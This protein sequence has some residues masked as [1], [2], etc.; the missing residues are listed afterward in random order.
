MDF[1]LEINRNNT[2]KE[3]E[4]EINRNNNQKEINIEIE[5]T[6]Q[7]IEKTK[8]EI[9]KTKQIDKNLEYVNNCYNLF[10]DDRRLLIFCMNKH[11]N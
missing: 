9:E 3:I 2:Q 11:F 4:I 8:Q 1:F 10:N 5:K 6:K 7:E